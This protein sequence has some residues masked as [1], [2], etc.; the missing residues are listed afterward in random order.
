[1]FGVGNATM[2]GFFVL[3]F[4]ALAAALVKA[5][6]ITSVTHHICPG[7]SIVADGLRFVGGET[8]LPFLTEGAAPRPSLEEVGWGDSGSGVGAIV[9]DAPLDASEG[10]VSMGFEGDPTVAAVFHYEVLYAR[11]RWPDFFE[12]VV[13]LTLVYHVPEDE[14]GRVCAMIT[15]EAFCDTATNDFDRD[16]D[17]PGFAGIYLT[18]SALDQPFGPTAQ[19]FGG[20]LVSAQTGIFGTFSM[21]PFYVPADMDEMDAAGEYTMP[22]RTKWEARGPP[23]RH[24]FLSQNCGEREFC[25]A[26]DPFNHILVCPVTAFASLQ[27]AADNCQCGVIKLDSRIEDDAGAAPI[28]VRRE[29]AVQSGE[30]GLINAT[31][32]EEGAPLFWVLGAGGALLLV[33]ADVATANGPALVDTFGM[34]VVTSSFFRSEV[35]PIMHITETTVVENSVFSLPAIPGFVLTHV[36]R[37]ASGFDSFQGAEKN[38]HALLRANRVE[39]DT[40]G[41]VQPEFADGFEVAGLL[42][43]CGPDATLRH[44]CVGGTFDVVER[45]C[46]CDRGCHGAICTD[47]STAPNKE[48]FICYDG[49][50]NVGFSALL[51]G[52]DTIKSMFKGEYAHRQRS[53]E[54]HTI[55]FLRD[56]CDVSVFGRKFCDEF[57]P[58]AATQ[59]N[60]I[61]PPKVVSTEDPIIVEHIAESIDWNARRQVRDAEK[62][63]N[64]YKSGFVLSMLYIFLFISINLWALQHNLVLI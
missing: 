19:A 16:D 7:S 51:L 45:T 58:P 52:E 55:M 15:G 56:G 46:T 20:P 3:F 41:G 6:E 11:P 36:Q 59:C 25:M 12:A 31:R 43:V 8:P 27:I 17:E 60:C 26:P 1:M 24:N 35:T 10:V 18:V 40:C 9:F 50:P 61:V 39:T 37:S 48:F 44:P 64:D 42:E 30:G 14:S 32:L 34:A 29:V 23:K 5:E 33:G 28:V 62:E 4:V 21:G 49:G 63:S 22:D 2:P 47:F 13:N 38:L 54:G 53:D 57:V